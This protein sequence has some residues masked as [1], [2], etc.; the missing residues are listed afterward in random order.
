M[1]YVSIAAAL[2]GQTV[3][4]ARASGSSIETPMMLR[5]RR[6]RM[7]VTT[8]RSQTRSRSYQVK[9]LDNA[10]D[11][12]ELH[13]SSRTIIATAKELAQAEADF[14]ANEQR[15]SRSKPKEREGV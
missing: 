8:T 6:G 5:H 2:T 1:R 13:D 3:R 11:Q 14:Y 15:G 9:A 4:D 7:I 12:S 10:K